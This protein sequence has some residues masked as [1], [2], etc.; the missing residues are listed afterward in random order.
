MRRIGIRFLKAGLYRFIFVPL[1]Y[2]IGIFGEREYVLGSKKCCLSLA[3]SY[4]EM[5]ETI[6]ILYFNKNKKN[7]ILIPFT[8]NILSLIVFT[9]IIKNI[10]FIF[11]YVICYFLFH[12]LML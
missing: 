9:L 1:M 11:H 3:L 2:S 12:I 4:L 5:Y 10:R 8:I 7:Y 6:L